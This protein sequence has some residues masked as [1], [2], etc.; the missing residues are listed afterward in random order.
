MGRLN[1]FVGS[2]RT[3]CWGCRSQSNVCNG[4]IFVVDTVFDEDVADAAFLSAATLAEE[5]MARGSLKLRPLANAGTTDLRTWW[6]T[7]RQ[8]FPEVCPGDMPPNVI[9]RTSCLGSSIPSLGRVR[10]AHSIS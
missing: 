7:V 10:S 3:N 5:V 9:D 6:E 4:P 8:V 2:G 1:I